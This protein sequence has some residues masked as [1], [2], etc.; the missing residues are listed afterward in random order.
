MPATTASIMYLLQTY[1]V[2][3]ILLGTF[4]LGETIVVAASFLAGGGLFSPLI[5]FVTAFIGTIAADMT[6][7]LIGQY[8]IRRHESKYLALRVK[9]PPAFRFLD[10]L[11]HTVP[12]WQALIAVKFV[13]GTRILFILYVSVNRLSRP[14]QFLFYDLLG[15]WLW[16]TPLVILGY[17]L[18][19]GLL[20]ETAMEQTKWIITSCIIFVLIIKAAS[21][22]LKQR[23]IRE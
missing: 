9:Y 5:V 20:T 19:R 3:A 15:V 1:Q 10:R 23:L 2:A 14:W 17:L 12:L 18:G 6:W 21:L 7:F 13:Y 4:I 8:Y 16:L 11:T 22:W